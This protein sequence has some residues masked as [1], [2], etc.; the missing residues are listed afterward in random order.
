MIKKIGLLV[1]V[2]GLSVGVAFACGKG[3]TKGAAATGHSAGSDCPSCS[4]SP[5]G[6][7]K[8][9]ANGPEKAA[10]AGTSVANVV[11]HDGATLVVRDAVSGEE[12]TVDDKTPFAD[13]SGSRYYFSCSG[14]KSMFQASPSS[15]IKPAADVKKSS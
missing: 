11:K 14:C 9:M 4:G 13:Y 7:Q 1:A 5:H 2:I 10:D 3:G 8:A 12:V 15:Y 6:G